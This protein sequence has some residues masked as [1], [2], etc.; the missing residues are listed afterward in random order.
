MALAWSRYIA[1]LFAI[2]LG[3]GEAVINWGRWQYAP[4]W[5]VDYVIVAWLLWAFVSTRAGQRIHLLL[6][7]W[8]FTSG[9]FYMAL[10]TS[11]DPQLGLTVSPVLLSL[12]GV[13]L[14][15]SV[16]GFFFALLTIRAQQ[17]AAADAAARRG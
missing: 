17:V 15:A 13:M 8:A 2:G 7:A 12:I 4:L 5:I 6:A 11:L 9:V 3:I 14:A 10:F 1:V 16:A